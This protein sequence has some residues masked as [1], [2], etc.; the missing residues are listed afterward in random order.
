MDRVH[1]A[2]LHHVAAALQ[3][4]GLQPV[5]LDVREPQ[6]LI[7]ASFEL[8]GVERIDVPMGQ[9]PA[10]LDTLAPERAYL[11]LCHHGVRSLRVAHFLSQHGYPHT[12]NIEGGIDAWS[13]QVDP[14]V[15][16]Y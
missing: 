1:V 2:D 10:H 14:G 9:I 4:H 15:P 16:R 11:V 13:L 12:Y 8:P 6:E 5:L 7:L 3:A